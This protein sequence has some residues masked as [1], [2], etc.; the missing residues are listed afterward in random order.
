MCTRGHFSVSCPV[1]EKKNSR[2]LSR[3][4]QGRLFFLLK[5]SSVSILCLVDSVVTCES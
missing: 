4:G 2:A 5:P 1:F 3:E